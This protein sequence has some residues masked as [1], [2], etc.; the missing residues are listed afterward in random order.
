MNSVKALIEE[1]MK[2]NYLVV[3]F[4]I[5]LGLRQ[6]L[7]EDARNFMK[8]C[9]HNSKSYTEDS[10]NVLKLGNRMCG[11]VLIITVSLVEEGL[12]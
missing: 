7:I 3:F 12:Y 4:T 11:Y 6:L 1:K 8:G 5:V 9:Y 10:P 2:G